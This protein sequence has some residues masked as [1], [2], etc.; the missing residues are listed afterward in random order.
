MCVGV[1][2]SAPA[3]EQYTNSLILSNQLKWIAQGSQAHRFSSMDTIPQPYYPDIV[4][5]KL[6]P[7]QS[8]E[9]ELYVEKG[10]GQ[11]HAKWS[12]VATASYRL[13]PEIIINKPVC[14]WRERERNGAGRLQWREKWSC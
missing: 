4:I 3:E 13:M 7:G 8:I 11:Q 10:I 9:A 1:P 6:R 2:E 14:R 5:A 12:P